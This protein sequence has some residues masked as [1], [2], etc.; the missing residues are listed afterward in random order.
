LAHGQT[1]CRGC[2]K[3]AK[4]QLIP[5]FFAATYNERLDSLAGDSARAAEKYQRLVR[6]LQN[7]R[8][9]VIFVKLEHLHTSF[10]NC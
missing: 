5:V 4:T 1:L 9:K 8:F 2:V 3:Q 6:V 7:F 10:I